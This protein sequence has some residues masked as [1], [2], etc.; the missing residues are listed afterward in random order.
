MEAC[1]LISNILMQFNFPPNQKIIL[2]SLFSKLTHATKKI[3][4]KSYPLDEAINL[5]KL[6][7]EKGIFTIQIGISEESDIESD[8]RYNNL[9]FME[10]KEL[11]FKI[12]SFVCV[13]NFYQHFAH[14]YDPNKKGIVIFSQ[15]DPKLFGHNSNINLIKDKKYL[16]PGK[17]QYQYWENAFFLQNSFVEPNIILENVIKLCQ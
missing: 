6:L 7:K 12:D 16:R 5:V 10:L 9:S 2:L 4:P 15:S 1:C 17:E 8:I 11:F 14:Y 13:D 3:S